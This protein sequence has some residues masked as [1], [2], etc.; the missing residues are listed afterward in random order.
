MPIMQSYFDCLQH[1][2]SLSALKI[3]HQLFANLLENDCSQ[4][5]KHVLKALTHKY[6][7]ILKTTCCLCVCIHFMHNYNFCVFQVAAPRN[8]SLFNS[9]MGDEP[10]MIYE[11]VLKAFSLE[12]I[13]FFFKYR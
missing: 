10:I 13:F 12:I 11:K 9:Q 5:K 7:H 8:S 2:G 1:V 4:L 6:H 3:R